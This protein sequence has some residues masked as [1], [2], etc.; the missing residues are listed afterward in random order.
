MIAAPTLDAWPAPPLARRPPRRL[1]RA[2]TI[3]IAV[4]LALHAGAVAY[5]AVRRFVLD[6]P[7][8]DPGPTTI[9]EFVERKPKPPEPKPEPAEP[10][11]PSV[12]VH[13]PPTTSTVE[14]M[15][16]SP[17][18]PVDVPAPPNDGPIIIA[19]GPS[20]PPIDLPPAP[21]APPGPRLIGKPDWLNRPNGRDLVRHYP[22]R[23]LDR[24][25][26]GRAVL[27]CGV[28]ASGRLVG[29]AVEAE[30]PAAAGFGAAALKLAPE[31]RMRPLTEDGQ[32]V[33]GGRVR[34]P[35]AFDLD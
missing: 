29:C 21:P 15:P 17:I 7:V 18:P 34:I 33:D 22:R 23:A 19:E 16:P 8:V 1:G 28:T 20:L 31:F 5:L 35:I 30:T 9:L 27:D 11:P 12:R 13:V 14:D 6:I 32:P 2:A 4:S 10:S 25:V 26:T 24:G 3:G